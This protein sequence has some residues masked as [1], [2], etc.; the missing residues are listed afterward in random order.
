MASSRGSVAKI[1]SFN[2]D[3]I[4][5]LYLS[6]FGHD[7]SI[8]VNLPAWN[9]CADVLVLHPHGLLPSDLSK[10]I[11]RLIVFTQAD[12]DDVIGNT[13]DEW[14]EAILGV[15]RSHTCLFIG[16]SGN[17][18]NLTSLL[19]KANDTHACRQTGELYWGIRFAL[20]GD[21][22]VPIWEKRG[23]FHRC[24]NDYAE[25]P[26]ILFDI[27]QHAARLHQRIVGL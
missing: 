10:P 27:C 21:A 15:F 13:S 24:V 18:R 4:I 22:L 9:R 20:D 25:I 6:Y 1:V 17:D 2:F 8:G 3:D 5:E 19:K 14:H 16:L 23:V 26:S 12:Y 7:I 11:P